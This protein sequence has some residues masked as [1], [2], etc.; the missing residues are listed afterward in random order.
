[1]LASLKLIGI[2]SKHINGMK[3]DNYQ[4]NNHLSF[5][6]FFRED[7][8]TPETIENNLSRALAICLSREPLLLDG[9]IMAIAKDDYD[10]VTKTPDSVCKVDIQIDTKTLQA[11]DYSKIYA[12]ALTAKD[13]T[14]INKEFAGL[15]VKDD[16]KK[17]I[18]DIIIE[19]NDILFVIEVKHSKE[20]CINQLKKQVLPFL[21]ESIKVIPV[22]FPWYKVIELM[23]QK[24]S[25]LKMTGGSCYFMDSFITLVE[26]RFSDWIPTK[27]FKYLSVQISPKNQ[28]IEKRLK[29]ALQH[30][31]NPQA[32]YPDRNSIEVNFGWASEIIPV[33]ELIDGRPYLT[34]NIWPGDTKAQGYE[35]YN[36]KM[37]WLSKKEI[38]IN[39]QKFP[40]KI[41]YEVNFRH[42]RR[43]ICTM[44]FSDE[45]N[46]LKKA[47]HT[48]ENFLKSG[49]KDRGKNDWKDF[50]EFMNGHFKDDYKWMNQC[51]FKEKFLDTTWQYL[52]VSFGFNVYAMIPYSFLQN[53]DKTQED[54]KDVSSFLDEAVKSFKKFI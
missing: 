36:E 35:I 15:K 43:T 28:E 10:L 14:N 48:R 29:L 1:M 42:N 33:I 3:K 25:I 54:Y 22:S 32:Y 13:F 34:I 23:Q 20:N 53:M 16:Q 49:K 27:P 19:L 6:N 8:E 9:F 7:K 31:S 50:I 52:T 40:V 46:Y 11:D 12:I 2:R 4:D 26:Q 5:F 18:T 21:S 17:T 41:E 44:Q 51:G 24:Q 39:K 30:C 38:T 37:D 45:D 47:L